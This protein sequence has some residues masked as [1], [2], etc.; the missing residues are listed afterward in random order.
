MKVNTA[1]RKML[2]GKPALGAAITLGS[3]IAGELY[4][5]QGWDFVLVDC[6][7]GNW[8]LDT[9]TAAFRSI[10]LGPAI[11][12]ARVRVNEFYAIGSLLDRGAMGLVIPMV[13]NAELAQ[14]A[15]FAARFP[16]RGG[17]S[18][19][20][21]G[22]GFHGVPNYERWI[23]EELFLAVQIETAE[24]LEN[25]E[26]ILSTEGI[27]GTWIGPADLANSL[28]LDLTTDSGRQKHEDAIMRVL[29]ACHKTGKVPGIAGGVAGERWLDKGF[30]FV[31]CAADSAAIN[32]TGR[33]TLE[34]LSKYR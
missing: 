16:P 22:T 34:F 28:G 20:G 18:Q 2:E 9:A 23:D 8:S 32:V 24:A 30:L 25:V 3:P 19:G 13:N 4:S 21:F 26:A 6:Q 14:R 17:R 1:K 7:H 12:M 5:L 27:D 31:T 10:S 11:P 33:Q 15:A 29:E